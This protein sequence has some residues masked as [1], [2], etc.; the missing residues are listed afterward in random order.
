MYK[1]KGITIESQQTSQYGADIEGELTK[2]LSVELVREIDRE[3]LRSMGFE[4][5]RK[6]RRINKINK[7]F[8]K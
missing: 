8:K 4:P 6:K 2:I 1:V 3:I 5:D 7:I